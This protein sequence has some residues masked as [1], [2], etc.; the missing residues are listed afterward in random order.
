MVG[1]YS[2]N[3]PYSFNRK[4]AKTHG[5]GGDIVGHP[6]AGDILIIDNVITAGTAIRESA[7]N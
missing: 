4:A 6:L 3:A 7:T 1:I 2:K 5:K